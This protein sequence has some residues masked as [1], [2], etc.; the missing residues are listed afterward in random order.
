[1]NAKRVR[2]SVKGCRVGG[3]TALDEA[4]LRNMGDEALGI[5]TACWY[6]A[7]LDNSLD[8]WRT[9]D[10]RGSRDVCLENNCDI[11]DG[12]SLQEHKIPCSH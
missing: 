1:M 12:C 7:E 8:H 4:V 10:V 11:G 2:M 3:M 6:S 9:A 5:V